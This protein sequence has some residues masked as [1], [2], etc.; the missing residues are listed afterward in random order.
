MKNDFEGDIIRPDAQSIPEYYFSLTNN[1]CKH[2]CFKHR[3]LKSAFALISF[4]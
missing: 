4:Y 3:Y 2:L 1:K